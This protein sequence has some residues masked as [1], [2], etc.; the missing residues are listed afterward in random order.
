MPPLL[1]AHAT[2]CGRSSPASPVSASRSRDSTPASSSARTCSSSAAT[3][4]GPRP[5]SGWR[6]PGA[7]VTPDDAAVVV[8]QITAVLN[9]GIALGDSGHNLAL[10]ASNGTTTRGDGSTVAAAEI[11][12]GDAKAVGN[13]FVAT[14]CQAIGATVSCNPPP[15]KPKTPEPPTPEVPE[16]LPEV[17][18]WLCARLPR[19]VRIAGLYKASCRVPWDRCC[20]RTIR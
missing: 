16:G 19:P 20:R 9:I 6:E 5:C 17:K 7:E 8:R 13:Q 11:T 3:S 4:P 12:T 15:D 18:R 14:V 10:V 1:A 2:R